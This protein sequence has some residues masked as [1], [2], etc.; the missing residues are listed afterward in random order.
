MLGWLGLVVAFVALSDGVTCLLGRPM[1]PEY[2]SKVYQT[3]F[4]IPLLYASLMVASP[5]FEET[6]FRG[7][8]VPGILQ[9]R[10]GTLGAI[11][12]PTV[13]WS[14]MHIQYDV[15]GIFHIFIGGILLGT[16]RLKSKSLYPAI[17]MHSLMNLIATVEVVLFQ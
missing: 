17:A 11:L 4:S 14:I 8:M 1:V 13:V 2:M 12:I 10:L 5:V 3:A 16:A 6:L 9:S 7:F 15:Y